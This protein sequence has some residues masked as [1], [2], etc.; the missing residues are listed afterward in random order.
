[1]DD[2]EH[3]RRVDDTVDLHI[4]RIHERSVLELL[5][6]DIQEFPLKNAIESVDFLT[7]TFVE[8]EYLGLGG[9]DT[10]SSVSHSHQR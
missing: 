3:L 9:R 6:V 2:G 8:C 5:G 7:A 4:G 10:F 1:M